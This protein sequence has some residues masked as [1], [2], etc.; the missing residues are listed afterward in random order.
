LLVRNAYFPPMLRRAG[1][2]VGGFDDFSPVLP[3][4]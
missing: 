2:S 3:M 1:V 4:R